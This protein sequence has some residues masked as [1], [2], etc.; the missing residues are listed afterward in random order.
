MGLGQTVIPEG[1]GT[2]SITHLSEGRSHLPP[3]TTSI[4]AY[5]K[6]V[7]SGR[8]TSQNERIMRY[9]L[10]VKRPVTRNEMCDRFFA[11]GNPPRALDGGAPIK[12]RSLGAR[13]AGM[14]DDYLVI[15]H[16]GP[17]PVTGADR[18]EFLAPKETAWAARRIF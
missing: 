17:D 11:V 18:V 3:T 5:H 12:W 8:A 16:Y 6:H 13:V 15:T 1:V 7:L 14:K 9:L 10:Q 4:L 2:E